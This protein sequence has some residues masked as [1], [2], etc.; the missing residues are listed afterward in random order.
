M[1]RRLKQLFVLLGV[2]VCFSTIA[3]G[4]T[5]DVGIVTYD[6]ISAGQT[7]FDITN[8]TGPGASGLGFPITTPLTISITSLVVNF[9]SG[10]SLVL[11][12][13]DFTVVD[14]DDD[15]DCA[16]ATTPACNLFGDSITSA[17]LTGTLSPTTGLAGLTGGDTGILAGFSSTVLPSS[18]TT[19]VDG[20][21]GQ[22]IVATGVSATGAVPE[23]EAVWLLGTV[24]G[25]V[26]IGRRR[27]RR[28][29]V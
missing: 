23:P 15:L 2:T 4:D 9:T 12:G 29:A 1:V 20:V 3:F 27:M 25:A 6:T 28:N 13:S 5:Y 22:L 16:V 19:L 21:D 14:S 8:G 10:P 11:P 24:I 17:T 26:F 18:G 7:E